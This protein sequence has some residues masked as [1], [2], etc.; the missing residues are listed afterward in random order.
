MRR[1]FEEL[2]ENLEEFVAQDEYPMLVVGC[3][4]EE[5]A[6]VIKFFQGLEEPH[7]EHFLVTFPQP[8]HTAAL[9]VD[10]VVESVRLQVEAAGPL[11]AARRECPFPPIPSEAHDRGLPPEARLFAAL[12]YLRGLLPDEDEHRV[13]VG[14]LPLEC[15]DRAA[16]RRLVASVMPRDEVPPWMGALRLVA[17]DDRRDRV[18]VDAMRANGVTRVLTFEVDL[19]TPALT[20]ALSRAA[21][22]PA[23]PVMERMTSL[24]Q[25][26]ALD[27]SYQRYPDALEKYGALF[28]FYGSMG[29]P[30]M[31]ALCLHGVGDVLRATGDPAAAK[32]R[33]Q[34]GLALA[35][36][37]K[38]LAPMLNLLLS[39]TEVC[40]ELRH[41]PDAERFAES[42]TKVAAAVMNV[43]AYC[44]LHERWGDALVAQQR[45]GEGLAA[46]KKCEALCGKF[47]Y[48]PRLESVLE[49]QVRLFETARM[50]AER[51][52]AESA[53]AAARAGTHAAPHGAHP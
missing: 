10:G 37:H 38:A 16:Y 29:L 53:L 6:Y 44:D 23:L 52:E 1:K 33:Y 50:G 48:G 34:Q 30:A 47:E 11:R 12:M 42:G 20:D 22:D 24:H 26:A 28:A 8:F 43:Y 35:M 13:V 7:P 36:E 41:Y 19:S 51:R 27:Y 45:H 2:R 49:R 17:C 40:F 31:Q 18:L 9:Y 15:A 21:A 4:P 46:Y 25:L 5:L 14:L 32:G 39:A 3:T